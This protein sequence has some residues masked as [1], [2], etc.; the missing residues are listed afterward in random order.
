[1]LRIIIVST[2]ICFLVALP[3]IIIGVIGINYC[4]SELNKQAPEEMQIVSQGIT[5]IQNAVVDFLVNNWFTIFIVGSLSLIVYILSN[6]YY[7]IRLKNML[8]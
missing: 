1:M 4:L 2:I 6:I 8:S 7:E 5:N 3:I